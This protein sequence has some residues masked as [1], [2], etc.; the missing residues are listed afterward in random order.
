MWMIVMFDLP[1][2][3]ARDKR[4]YQ[5]FR[6]FILDE[7]FAM[8]QYSVYGRHCA[9]REIAANKELRV[10]RSLPPRGEVR[11][12]TVTDAQFARMRIYRENRRTR[13]EAPASQLE[14]W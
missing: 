3:T 6:S 13:P 1:T 14:F 7:G 12:L 5:L 8:L 11:V 9:T 10:G 4:N 2:E